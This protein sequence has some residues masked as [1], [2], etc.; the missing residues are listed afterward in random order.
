MFSLLRLATQYFA[1]E[2]ITVEP[3][4]TNTPNI[5]IHFYL[6]REVNL[7]KRNFI[8]R[9]IVIHHNYFV[10]TYY[11][12]DEG[13]N[14]RPNCTFSPT[15]K[16][17]VQQRE[18]HCEVLT[19]L[20]EADRIIPHCNG[21]AGITW[22]GG[23]AFRKEA[24]LAFIGRAIAQSPSNTFL[25]PHHLQGGIITPWGE[26]HRNGDTRLTPRGW[27]HRGR[28]CSY[29]ITFREGATNKAILL[30]CVIQPVVPCSR[31]LSTGVPWL[32]MG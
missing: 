13:G 1:L 16:T 11:N 19:E 17:E 15:I 5:E 14:Y 24:V 18:V 32:I 6:Q 31:V 20:R 10:L 7:L 23:E 28:V 29:K 9:F 22:Y 30:T 4:I 27:V 12:N 3:P 25:W 8:Q 21:V 2:L 26:I